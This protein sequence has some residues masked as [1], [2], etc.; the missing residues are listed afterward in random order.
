M[1]HH[2]AIDTMAAER[3]ILGELNQHERD[4]FEEHFFDCPK[5]SMSVRDAAKIAAAVRLGEPRGAAIP[6]SRMNW[7]AAAA[8]SVI[9]A[10]GF[11]YRYLL[12]MATPDHPGPAPIHG[13]AGDQQID[14]DSAR[15]VEVAYH[16]RADQPV[17]LNFVVPPPEH[18]LPFYTCELLDG[19]DRIIR[20]MT[21]MREQA[22]NPVPMPLKAQT[23]RTG[24]YKVVI[25]GGDREI[26]AYPFTVEA[27]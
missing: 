14:L 22:Q 12:Q 21:V 26:A 15:A 2:K 5:C 13:Q 8:A 1:D 17:V 24:R 9:V 25:R 11:N 16:L 7:W 19:A 20:T 23:L 4:A 3:Y 18:P 27:W 6:R 10:A